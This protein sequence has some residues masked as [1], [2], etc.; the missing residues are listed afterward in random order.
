MRLVWAFV[1]VA[2]PA[3]ATTMLRADLDELVRRSDRVLRARVVKVESHWSGDRTHIVTDT[4]LAVLEDLKGGGATRVTVRQ[5]GGVVGDIGQQV[6][7]LASFRQGEEVVV[8]LERRGPFFRVSGM[9]QGKYRVVRDAK[10]AHAVPESLGDTTLIDRQSGQQV[11]SARPALS[12]D[13]LRAAVKRVG[14][15]R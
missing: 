8:L 3:F 1:L 13:A 11:S 5:P 12:L 2:F 10:G 7:G 14:A 9:A 6:S 15:E 4:E